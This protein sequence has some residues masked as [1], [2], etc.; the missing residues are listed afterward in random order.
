MLRAGMMTG[1]SMIGT[2]PSSTPALSATSCMAR[3]SRRCW[4]PT[5][6][7]RSGWM[8]SVEGEKNMHATA[9]GRSLKNSCADL[10]VVSTM[11]RPD[12]HNQDVE[13]MVSTIL[14]PLECWT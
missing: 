4:L 10:L 2:W 14:E 7:G 5:T 6:A 12:P 9:E 13:R 8:W 3:S 11:A 1:I